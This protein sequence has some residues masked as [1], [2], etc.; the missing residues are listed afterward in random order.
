LAWT[1]HYKIKVA[2]AIALIISGLF[3]MVTFFMGNFKF[4]IN[5][6]YLITHSVFVLIFGKII[7][8][9]LIIWCLFK[10]KPTKRYIWSYSII[11]VVLY[12]FVMQC[13]G[14]ISNLY[15]HK[16]YTATVGTPQEIQPMQQEQAKNTY[17]KFI[18]FNIY[19]PIF[20]AIVGF[21]LFEKIYLEAIVI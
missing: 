8:I 14:G 4:E 6:V 17:L 2:L 15:V 19:L 10:V 16:E 18:I 20:M 12:V 9:G 3:D 21:Y 7:A 1:K 11:L 13:L 5:I